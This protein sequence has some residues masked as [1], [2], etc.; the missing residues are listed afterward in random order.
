[1]RLDRH[2]TLTNAVLLHGLLAAPLAW[3]AQ[4]VIGYGIGEADCAEGSR[5]SGIDSGAWELGLTVVAGA[6]AVSGLAAA[7][8]S[9]REETRHGGDERGRI[10]FMATGGILVSAVFVVLILLGG[11]AAVFFAHCR[12][13]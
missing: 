4:L 13:S 3:T 12:G 6:Y 1:M 11:I 2:S 8:W 10:A 5:R 9:H 7:A